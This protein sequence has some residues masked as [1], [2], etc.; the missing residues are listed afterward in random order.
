MD[1]YDKVAALALSIRETPEF[2]EWLRV[3]ELVDQTIDEKN[4]LQ[5]YR[6]CQL[7]MEFAD[8]TDASVSYLESASDEL[9]EL[10]DI[11]MENPL[12]SRYLQA[13]ESFCCMLNKMQQVFAKNMDFP[14]DDF[15]AVQEVDAFLN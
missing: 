13:E 8:I 3:K 10:Y 12:L 9:D 6:T 14:I 15:F 1:I 11:M 4:V 5:K 2:V 7:A